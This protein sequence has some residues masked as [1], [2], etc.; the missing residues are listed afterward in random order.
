MYPVAEGLVREPKYLEDDSPVPQ[1][2][3]QLKDRD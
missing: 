3:E 1:L 2:P